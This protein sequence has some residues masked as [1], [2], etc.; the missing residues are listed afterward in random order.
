MFQHIAIGM[1]G[2][3]HAPRLCLPGKADV[4]LVEQGLRVM[5]ERYVSSEPQCLGLIKEIENLVR[6]HLMEHR[7]TD[8]IEVL[9][10][11]VVGP[12]TEPARAI[13]VG[14]GFDQQTVKKTNPVFEVRGMES[15]HN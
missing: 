14:L 5:V 6:R 12:R 11:S 4:A 10:G 2:G 1:Q 15:K 13:T 3:F 7:A 8:R 9:S